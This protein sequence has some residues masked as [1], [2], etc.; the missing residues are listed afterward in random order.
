VRLFSHNIT[1]TFISP[2][3]L[4]GYKIV[5]LLPVLSAQ[6]LLRVVFITIVPDI[7]K[8][9]NRILDPKNWLPFLLYKYI[10]EDMLKVSQASANSKKKQNSQAKSQYKSSARGVNSRKNAKNMKKKQDK[11][12]DK[13]FIMDMFPIE[14]EDLNIFDFNLL[15]FNIF[16]FNIFNFNKSR[17]TQ[18]KESNAGRL[19]M[20]IRNLETGQAKNYSVGTRDYLDVASRNYS[21]S[22]DDSSRQHSNLAYAAPA[23]QPQ[24]QAKRIIDYNSS[25]NSDNIQKNRYRGFHAECGE[26]RNDRMYLELKMDHPNKK[27]FDAIRDKLHLILNFFDYNKKN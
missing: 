18:K 26:R 9:A 8:I 6:H 12:K 1:E 15:D 17:P 5:Y 22:S 21:Y 2:Y 23:N 25:Y 7:N 27:H 24:A 19:D 3:P 20:D 4:Y 16:D 11:R 14:R 10:T 13:S